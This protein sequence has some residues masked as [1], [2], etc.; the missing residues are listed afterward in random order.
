MPIAIRYKVVD[1]AYLQLVIDIKL[2]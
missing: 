2:E 1:D